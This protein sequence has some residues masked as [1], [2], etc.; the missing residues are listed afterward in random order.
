MATFTNKKYGAIYRQQIK[1][2]KSGNTLTSILMYRISS[3]HGYFRRF[4]YVSNN[5]NSFN[6]LFS[7]I[8]YCLLN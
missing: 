6:I 4:T 1:K 3:S 2:A 5:L 7:L 8:Y